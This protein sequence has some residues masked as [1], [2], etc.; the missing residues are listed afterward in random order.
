[1]SSAISNDIGRIVASF[2]VLSTRLKNSFFLHEGEISA[3]RK[4]LNTSVYDDETK[5]STNG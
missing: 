2:L 5:Y 4:H 3:C 1:M